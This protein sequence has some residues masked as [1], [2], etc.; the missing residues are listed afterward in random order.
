MQI[1][2]ETK[3]KED[4]LNAL[5][6]QLIPGRSTDNL[7]PNK[8]SEV[9]STMIVSM[10]LNEASAKIR[11]GFSNDDKVDWDRDVWSGQIPLHQ[12]WGKPIN[13]PNMKPGIP[14]PDYVLEYSR[15]QPHKQ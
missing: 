8:K 6:E 10:P 5:V 12:V 15:E 7:R 13:N 14:A 4:A 3:E 11:T 1:I 9:T 2:T